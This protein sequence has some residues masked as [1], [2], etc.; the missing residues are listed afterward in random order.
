METYQSLDSYFT[1][2]HESTSPTLDHEKAFCI[3]LNT[4]SFNHY[5]LQPFIIRLAV[6]QLP[7]LSQQIINKGSLSGFT[8]PVSLR[9]R[10]RLEPAS[11]PT[12]SVQVTPLH[13][14]IQDRVSIRP[15]HRNGMY[16]ATTLRG[17]CTA[18]FRTIEE[19]IDH[20]V[21]KY[22]TDYHLGTSFS[23]SL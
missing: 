3:L 21:N 23:V 5:S 12:T 11:T 14:E 15:H 22:S 16:C 9:D 2:R 17:G 20:L 13:S 7:T 10:N 4:V 6:H 1:V 8:F 18:S 19:L